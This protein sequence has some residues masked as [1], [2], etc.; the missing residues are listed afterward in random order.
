[1]FLN[2]NNK[3]R[4]TT[5]NKKEISISIIFDHTSTMYYVLNIYYELK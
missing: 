5:T 4:T 3:R 2:K 1:L